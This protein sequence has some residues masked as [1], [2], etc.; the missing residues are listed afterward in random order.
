M[1]VFM[2]R[3]SNQAAAFTGSP[4]VDGSPLGGR[5][6]PYCCRSPADKVLFLVFPAFPAE[7]YMIAHSSGDL[8]YAGLKGHNNGALVRYKVIH[9]D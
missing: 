3:V 2:Q 8:D 5:C 6:L 9:Y 7:V 4:K 1:D